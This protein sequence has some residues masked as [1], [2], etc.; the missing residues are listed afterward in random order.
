MTFCSNCGLEV[1][2]GNA[3]CLNCGQAVSVTNIQ[4]PIYQASRITERTT[5]RPTG[6]AIL[7]VLQALGGLASL[8][9]GIL[10]LIGAAF[11]GGFYPQGVPGFV[12][13]F[14]GVVGVILIILAIVNFVVVY[15]FWTG[16]GWSWTIGI[17]V[18]G[19]SIITSLASLPSSLFSLLING[20]IIYY[21]T[22]PYV[23]KFFGK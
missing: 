8:A 20:A 13:G 2:E 15:G 10:G 17:V 9:G 22:R 6:V 5:E 12:S 14:V 3:F 1:K 4:K 11:L 7:S 16:Q 23:K 19:I 18:A 21:L